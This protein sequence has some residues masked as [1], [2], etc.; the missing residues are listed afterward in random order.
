MSSAKCLLFCLNLNV[1]MAVVQ[2][3]RIMRIHERKLHISDP[4]C[5][6]NTYQG[7]ILI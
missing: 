2:T 6:E 1:L 7:P 3:L 4:L 5:G